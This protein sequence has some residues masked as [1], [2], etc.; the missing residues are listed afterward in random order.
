MGEFAAGTAAAASASRRIVLRSIPVLR[1]ISCCETAFCSSVTTVL[2]CCGVKTFTPGPPSNGGAIMSCRRHCG[3]RRLQH[4]A[5]LL[6]GDFEV[7]ITGGVWVAAG[8]YDLGFFDH[9][10]CRLEP[11]AN[12]FEAKVL[13]MSPA[14]CVRIV[15]ASFEVEPLRGENSTTT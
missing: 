10:T 5:Y 3:Y 4:R 1:L 12:P 8:D 7:A 11:A 13:P 6:L 2:L 14:P 15:V 9:E